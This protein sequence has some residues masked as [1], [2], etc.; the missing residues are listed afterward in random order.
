VLV[1]PYVSAQVST[2]AVAE[3]ATP[4]IVVDPEVTLVDQEG[5]GKLYRVAD[6]WLVVMEGT[7]SE[8]GFQHG[9]LLAKPIRHIIKEGYMLK[10]FYSRGYTKEYIDAQSER[11]EKHFPPEYI[12]EMRGLVKGLEAA[13]VQ[14]IVYE[15]I[16]TAVTQ[17]ELAHHRPNEPPEL[18]RPDTSPPPQQCSN[19][20]VWGKWTKDGRL[21]H[22]RNLDWNI[23]DGAQEN[24]LILVWRPVN[25]VPFMM[26]GWTGGIGSVSGMN[27]KG[28]TIGEMTSVSSEESFDG[29]PLMLIMRRALETAGTLDEA[30]AVIQKGPRTTG[31]NFVIGDGKIPSARALEV[32]AVDC[33]GFGPMD[34]KETEETGHW[35][36]EDAVRR[37]NHPIGMSQLRKLAI[38]FGAQFGIDPDNIKAAIPLL[39]LQNTWQRYDWLGKQIMA[40]PGQMDVTEAVQLLANKPVGGK[41]TKTL[42]SFVFDP[43]RKTAYVA[44]AAANP[45]VPAP[46]TQF[47]K[48]DL[49]EW[50]K[51][52]MSSPEPA[53]TPERKPKSKKK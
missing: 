15:D 41:D 29:L 20:A 52:R 10:A 42:H 32:D 30:V 7:P 23:A 31:W 49:T 8:M 40:R 38:R 6:Q 53:K 50:F 1:T 19:F 18:K 33:G 13:G 11:M 45:P 12:E 47:V 24:A 46:L 17:A 43:S 3:L 14:D 51:E 4:K 35:A 34:P 48:I 16:R 5:A 9:R 2:T 36:M 37:T 28:I 25:G 39:K 44:V 21:L 27:A 22:G 26:L